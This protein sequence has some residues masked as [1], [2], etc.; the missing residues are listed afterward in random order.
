MLREATVLA[1]LPEHDNLVVFLGVTLPPDPLCF[2]T[3]FY[4]GGSLYAY[5]HN[6]DLKISGITKVKSEIGE[7]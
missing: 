3:D 2:V 1:S 6:K 4:E 7:L 5:I